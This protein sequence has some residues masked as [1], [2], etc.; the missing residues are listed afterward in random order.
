[1]LG[2]SILWSSIRAAC[3]ERVLS[4]KEKCFRQKKMKGLFSLA[5]LNSYHGVIWWYAIH[6]KLHIQIIRNDMIHMNVLIATKDMGTCVEHLP[7][8]HKGH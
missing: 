3:T 5:S 6:D 7:C 1:M 8:Y 2:S 4:V